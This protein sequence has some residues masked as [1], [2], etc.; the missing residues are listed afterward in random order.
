MRAKFLIPI[1]PDH[2]FRLIPRHVIKSVFVFL[3]VLS[4]DGFWLM[5]MMVMMMMAMTICFTEATQLLESS[6]FAVSVPQEE[7]QCAMTMYN[8]Q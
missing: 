3:P 6:G 7:E 8:V 5:M 4:V 2:T 1:P